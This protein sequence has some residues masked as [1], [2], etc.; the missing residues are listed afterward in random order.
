MGRA[1]AF[2]VMMALVWAAAA[3]AQGEATADPTAL[4]PQAGQVKGWAAAEEAKTYDPDNLF[5][6]IDGAAETYLD[7][8]FVKLAACEFRP[9]DGAKISVVVD[10][11]DMGAADNAFGIYSN[12]AFPDANYIALGTE[13]YLTESSADFFKDRYYVKLAGHGKPREVQGAVQELAKAVAANIKAAPQPPRG[14]ALLP[15]EGMV[16]HTMK[17]FRGNALGQSFLKDA[18]QATYKIGGGEPQLLLARLDS[19]EK[20]QDAVKRFKAFMGEGGKVL[21]ESGDGF[22][23]EDPYYGRVTVRGRGAWFFCVLK[24]PGDEAAAKLIEG[25][26]AKLPKD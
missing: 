1:G 24:S 25:A 20:A 14:A 16:P 12:G 18:F 3:F 9:A 23:A 2:V 13:G 6:Y 15:A 11:Y 22:V 5:E 4:L 19:A 26:I 8:G 7:Y 17:Y 10:I 21:S